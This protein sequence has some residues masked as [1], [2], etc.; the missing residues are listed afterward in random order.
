VTSA[1]TAVERWFRAALATVDPEEAVGRTLKRDGRRLVIDGRPEGITG[2]VW[3]VAVGKAALPMAR[4]VERE[5]DELL[6]GGV[7]ITKDGH[8]SGEP[9]KRLEVFEAAHPIP[10]ERGVLATRRALAMLGAVDDGDLVLALISGGGSALL[11]APVP[12][13]TLS[14]MAKT[15]D[16]LL[17]AGAPIQDLNAV[18]TP[19][20][21]V[22]GGGL[23]RA[24]SAARFVTLVLS[25]VLGNDPRVIASG[26]TVPGMADAGSALTTLDR[27]GLQKEVPDAVLVAL[28][29]RVGALEQGGP[30]PGDAIV[31]IGDNNAALGG[32]RAAVEGDGLS[33]RVAWRDQGG[34]AREL[35]E[36][37]VHVC[38]EEAREEDVV[39][40][41]GEATVT[42]T[43]G[44]M[45]G[46]NTEF[47]LAAALELERQ[48]E[49]GW[50]I[51]SLAT[52]GQD[53]LTGA[54][55]AVAD[56][57]TTEQARRAG[58]EPAQALANNDSMAVFQVTGGL[59]VTGPTGTNVNDLYVGVRLA[60]LERMGGSARG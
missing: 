28:R 9:S 4:A 37:W 3:V 33:A 54:A 6:A 44:G 34:E 29:A 43:G 41:G 58:V 47:A 7:V 17:R 56:G 42:V 59:V 5:C 14:D 15:T 45:G 25:D 48:C 39:L 26:P 13:V 12:P 24:A 53:S 40:G 60:A 46:R 10:D 32:M 50:A 8:L 27:Y 19:L 23:R 35:G 55:G 2:K 31:V 1:Q 49:S 18:R 21:L 16:L 22:K 11:E 57:Q 30:E 38:R 36:S 51:A 52:D 20:S